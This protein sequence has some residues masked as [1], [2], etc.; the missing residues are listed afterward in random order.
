MNFDNFIAK[1]VNVKKIAGF[2]IDLSHFKSEE[3]RWTK[4]FDYI[5]HERRIKREFGCNH[6]GGFNPYK[7]RDK[8]TVTDLHDFD[9][10][11]TL[12]EFVFSPIVA[13]EMDNSIKEQLVFQKH[14]ERMID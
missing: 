9:Y 2:C 6:L 7:L 3:E 14:V 1:D 10:L 12:P 8:H 4:E 11:K 13:L 5:L